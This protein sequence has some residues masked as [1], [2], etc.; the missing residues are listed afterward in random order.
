MLVV[1]NE[2]HVQPGHEEEF[3]RLFAQ[4]QRLIL[5]EPGCLSCRLHRERT[6]PNVYV[7]YLE[8]SSFEALQAPHNSEITR[9]IEQYRLEEPPRRRRFDLV[10]E[11]PPY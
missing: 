11:S 8:W 1:I 2:F 9:L 7:S 3:E 10:G 4:V 5:K 6:A